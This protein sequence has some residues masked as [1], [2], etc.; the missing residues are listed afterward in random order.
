MNKLEFIDEALNKYD[1][2]VYGGNMPA[3][4]K[5]VLRN[6]LAKEYEFWAQDGVAREL[7][8]KHGEEKQYE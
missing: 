7:E 8:A 1:K 4:N 6:M 3:H 2:E 5:S